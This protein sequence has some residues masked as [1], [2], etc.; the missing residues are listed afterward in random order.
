MRPPAAVSGESPPAPARSADLARSSWPDLSD[1]A[2]LVLV[3]VGS[4]EQHGPHLPL[5][6][7][8]VIATEVARL[9][10]RRLLRC[11]ADVV[12]APA[13]TYGASGEHEGFAG[14]I[15]IGHEALYLLLV[16]YGRSA[17]RWA[18]GV[19]FVNGHGGNTEAGLRA[20]ETLRSEGRVALW[21]ACTVPGGDAHAGTTETSVMRYVVP[22]DVDLTQAVTG[23]TTPIEELM[24]L[25][26]SGG[27]QAV[28]PSGV[29]G[30]A[31]R[32]SHD[33]GRRAVEAMVH[34]LV[35]AVRA[36]EVSPRS[37][38]SR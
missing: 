14:T 8:T 13:L 19:L 33:E 31:T 2:P 36:L 32:S 1:R 9:A 18:R 35:L 27:L 11:G 6:T 21:A 3:P 4:V 38:A 26:R 23:S 37:A 30:D 7:D 22:A 17:C 29:L 10:G 20:A 15:S 34:A 28:S 5:A 16:E 12:V 24:P 25:L